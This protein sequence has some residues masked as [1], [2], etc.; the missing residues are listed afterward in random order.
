MKK[1]LVK[2][3]MVVAV[4]IAPH[5]AKAGIPVIDVANLA[6]AIMDAATM[7]K[8][9]EQMY[10]QY[11]QLKQQYE[12]ISGA[13]NL[14]QVLNSP[15]LQNYVPKDAHTV[16][17]SIN[18][19]GKAGLTGKAK[20]LRDVAMV[21]DCGELSGA[22][23]SRCEAELSKPYQYQAYYDDALERGSKRVDQINQLMQLA[24]TTEDAKEIAEVQAR[25]A[26]ES[27]LLQHEL[28]QIQLVRASSEADAQVQLARAREAQ[29]ENAART[30]K[31]GANISSLGL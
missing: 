11:Q 1:T 27:A 20:A 12:A 29:R 5:T 15:L 25:I 3:M 22:A 17:R 28:S 2:L 31:L 18:T 24:G 9:L 19:L 26:A 4:W 16:L 8:E 13:R 6:Q 14:G 30:G 7:I 23:R 10:A 21:Y